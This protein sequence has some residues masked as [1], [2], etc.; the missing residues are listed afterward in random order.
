[1]LP[2]ELQSPPPREL[3]AAAPLLAKNRSTIR[4]MIVGTFLLPPAVV[5]LM[6]LKFRTVDG[7]SVGLALGIGALVGLFAF[8]LSVQK[9]RAERLFREGTAAVGKVKSL[10]TPGD[11]QGNAYI[12]AHIEFQDAG[13][14]V[15]L[16]QVTS[17]G[18]A[19]SVDR[20]EGDEVAVLYLE[21]DAKAFAIYSPGLG[22]VPGVIRG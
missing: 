2:S 17:V 19:S 4:G 22:I 10:E 6:W 7:L 16:G 11:R 13:G 14:K 8:A 1:M 15:R 5:L 18:R 3:G 21:N 20:R 9:K 12:I